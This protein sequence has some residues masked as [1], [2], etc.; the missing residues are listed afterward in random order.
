MSKSPIAATK[1]S[2][3]PINVHVDAGDEEIHDTVTRKIYSTV[4]IFGDAPSTT[5]FE[6]PEA[7]VKKNLFEK[8]KTFLQDRP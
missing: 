1:I 7:K 3:S 4:G 6:R 5:E 2:P 8:L